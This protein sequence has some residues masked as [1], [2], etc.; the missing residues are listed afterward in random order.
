M[1]APE[2]VKVRRCLSRICNNNTA[3][4]CDVLKRGDCSA[5]AAIVV[6]YLATGRGTDRFPGIPILI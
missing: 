4:D 3:G 5:V 1:D 2:L 6:S